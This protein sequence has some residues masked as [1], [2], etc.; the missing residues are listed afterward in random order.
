M[1]KKYSEDTKIFWIAVYSILK[2]KMK[3][4]SRKIQL[5]CIYVTEN[6]YVNLNVR[7]VTFRI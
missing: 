5:E 1:H 7:V 3:L 6:D 2:F 4:I